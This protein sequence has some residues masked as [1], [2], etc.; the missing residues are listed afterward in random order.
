MRI[1]PTTVDDA[2]RLESL[3][4]AMTPEDR[5]L[6]FFT[7][8]LP[9]PDW[10][11]SWASI[12]DRGG[13]G[14][15]ATVEGE[16]GVESVAGEAGYALRWDGDGDL[17]VTVAPEWR[18]WLGAYLLDRIVEYAAANGVSSLQA[19]VLDDNAPM[20]RMLEH[21]GAV[22]F[23]HPAGTVHLS[24]GTASHVPTWP[25]DDDRRRV[26]VEVAGGRW[27]GE[28]RATEDGLAVAT[29]RG[30]QRREREGC[31]VLS[32]GRCPLADGADAIVVLLDPGDETTHRLIDAHAAQNP[33]TPVF[34]RQ[35]IS[36]S[37]VCETLPGTVDADLR[38]V[39]DRLADSPSS[40]R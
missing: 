13:F 9:K 30:P 11:E 16:D 21:R 40:E 37:E 10:C 35:G 8:W 7:A 19:D 6:R 24:I 33:T 39:E 17:A 4:A 23:E 18:G 28:A 12:R 20:R 22:T 1:R 5:R 29:C 36:P 32:G 31:P 27:A 25:P 26:L 34:I 14:V 3:Y 2:D 38:R 15:I